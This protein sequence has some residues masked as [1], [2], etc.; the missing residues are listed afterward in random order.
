MSLGEGMERAVS[1]ADDAVP[2]L[3]RLI[4][5]APK[6]LDESN[7][8]GP[9]I[10]GLGEAL[11]HFAGSVKHVRD[12]LRLA[13][14]IETVGE[15]LSRET[16]TTRR[17]RDLEVAGDCSS[18]ELRRPAGAWASTARAAVELRV[19]ES[20]FDE[21]VEVERRQRPPD[22]QRQSSLVAVHGHGSAGDVLVE[23]ASDR[24]CKH[25]KVVERSGRLVVH[26]GTVSHISVNERLDTTV[27][28]G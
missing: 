12:G 22:S 18:V 14:A 17:Q 1:E 3:E 24:L 7:R 2:L 15:D 28:G 21:S 4:A 25:G 6:N 16:V 5:A 13:R 11:A 26:G 9:G 27:R 20:A 19:E 23:A 8:T 10:G